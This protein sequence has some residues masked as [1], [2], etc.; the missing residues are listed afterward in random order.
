MRPWRVSRYVSLLA[1]LT[2]ITVAVGNFAQQH[3]V[4]VKWLVYGAAAAAA[5]T[6]GLGV[7]LIPLGLLVAKGMAVRFLLARLGIG[8]NLL[9]PL[10][11]MASG[12]MGM[13]ARL[14]PLLASAWQVALPVLSAFG[15][16]LMVLGRFL[17]ATPLGA[18]LSLLAVAGTML[19]T[20]W[21][22]IKGGAV[23][24]WEDMVALKDRFFDAGADLVGG[25][26]NGIAQKAQAL[27]DGVVGI[28][29]D[30]AS[31]F[32][33]RLG[34]NSP[35]RV[36]MEFGGWIS[37]GAALGIQK[38]Q[39]LAAAAAV[40]LAAT[41]TAPM[42]MAGSSMLAR[43]AAPM[44]TAA[45]AGGSTYQI[46]IHAAPGMDPQAI[47]QAVRQEIDRRERAQRSRVNSQFS[48]TE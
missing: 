23:A 14:G 36:F 43:P 32:K 7:L 19:Y 42:A 3:P 47:A 38:G 17:L 11:R 29:S 8:F 18:A 39:H 5:L 12:A 37:E 15:Q 30:V 10:A 24:L 45:P 26:V 40:G 35:S 1:T 2:K 31:W 13:L 27:R 41:T 33:E 48:D 16:G 6:A 44:M 21:A 22:D 20:R 4:M 25:L 28:A 46:T 9:A 34:I